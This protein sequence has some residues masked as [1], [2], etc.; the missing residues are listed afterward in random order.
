V[1]PREVCRG[2]DEA[3]KARERE[4]I[5]TLTEIPCLGGAGR[6]RGKR[7]YD[8]WQLFKGM[9]RSIGSSISIV[10]FRARIVIAMRRTFEAPINARD[11][12][13]SVRWKGY[14]RYLGTYR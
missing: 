1:L 5:D 14:S 13:E 7:D 10:Y 8:N 9:Y 11:I 4:I 12:V 2:R 3:T 6:R